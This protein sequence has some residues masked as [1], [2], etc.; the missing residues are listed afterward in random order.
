MPRYPTQVEGFQSCAAAI[1][2]RSRSPTVSSGGEVTMH[3]APGRTVWPRMAN[4]LD[5][6]YAAALDVGQQEPL[7][8]F[9]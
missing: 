9:A 5:E 4:A 8:A 3:R 6:A 2:V 1:H 7:N